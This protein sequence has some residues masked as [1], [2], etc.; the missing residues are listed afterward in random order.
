[1]RA[2][3][4][5]LLACLAPLGSAQIDDVFSDLGPLVRRELMDGRP[6]LTAIAEDDPARDVVRDIARL[7]QL[8]IVGLQH[9][10]KSL[11][12]VHLEARELKDILTVMLGSLGLEHERHG[13]VLEIRPVSS[14]TSAELFA[15]A[16]SA[17]LDFY[18]RFPNH[19][20]APHAQFSRAEIKEKTNNLS[21]ARDL[22]LKLVKDYPASMEMGPALLRAG[23]L[24]AKQGDTAQAAQIFRNLSNMDIPDS[25]QAATRVELARVLIT[26]GDP[27]QALNLLKSMEVDYPALDEG[28]ATVRRLIR[29]RAL[30]K[31]GKFV[32]ALREIDMLDRHFDELS[33]WESLH[34]RATAFEGMGLHADASQAWLYYATDAIGK[35]RAEAYASAARL[36][37]L[38][39]DE[40]AVRFIAKT[41][42]EAGFDEGLQDYLEEAE[43]RLGM[44]DVEPRSDLNNTLDSIEDL[45]EQG[46]ILTAM[47]KLKPL[48]NR[49]SRML[50]VDLRA[51]LSVA[52]AR[53]IENQ[54]GLDQAIQ[55]LSQER[56]TFNTTEEI[57]LIDVAAA[58]LFEKHNLFVEAVKAYQGEYGQ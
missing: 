50:E 19:P 4:P 14:H 55:L 51:R 42:A 40:L 32:N 30:N 12:S 46:K 47:N 28:E 3:L 24:S 37:L 11:V 53:C 44:V 52:W 54:E 5:M 45:I 29:A 6:R 13:S 34:I 58:S 26:Q 8:E 15:L 38:A 10:D 9:L 48:F 17:W 7:Y 43:M 1:M 22:Y 57:A 25:L 39:N 41:A 35:D 20:M 21:A 16:D 23:H 31:L 33:A 36:A 27:Q 49:R 2:L 56:L 18:R